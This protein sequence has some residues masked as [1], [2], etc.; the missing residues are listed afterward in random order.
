MILGA[1]AL[2]LDPATKRY[3]VGGS[4][5]PPRLLYAPAPVFPSS[6][7]RRKGYV[8]VWVIIDSAGRVRYPKIAI[9]LEV[10]EENAAALANVRLWKFQPAT[11]DGAQVAIETNLNVNFPQ[12]RRAVLAEHAKRQKVGLFD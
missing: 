11:K 1:D 7:Y 4:V 2:G 3:R 6:A 9:G 10:A 12:K 5:K 8:I